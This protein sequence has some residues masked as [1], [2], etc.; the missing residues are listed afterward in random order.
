MD[1]HFVGTIRRLIK[2]LAFV[3]ALL[4]DGSFE[5]IMSI[6]HQ[7]QTDDNFEGQ[8]QSCST[9]V[10]GHFIFWEGCPV[11][12]KERHCLSRLIVFSFGS[13]LSA[14]I[15]VAICFPLVAL[16]SMSTCNNGKSEFINQK[17]IGETIAQ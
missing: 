3:V 17:S 13:I 4:F 14:K 6:Q 16:K 8:R 15:D 7:H 12:L 9:K 1:S 10:F 11:F 5:I 2:L